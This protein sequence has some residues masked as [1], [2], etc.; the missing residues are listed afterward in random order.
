MTLVW[1][2]VKKKKVVSQVSKNYMTEPA[3]HPASV[4]CHANKPNY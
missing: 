2:K 4:T 3:V 1:N